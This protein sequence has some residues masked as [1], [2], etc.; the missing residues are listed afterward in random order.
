MKAMTQA[1]AVLASFVVSVLSFPMTAASQTP[2]DYLQ[3]LAGQKLI[4]R[5][6]GD[7]KEARVNKNALAKVKGTCDV[8]VQVHEAVWQRKRVR[9]QWS[10]IGSPRIAGKPGRVCRKTIV[11]SDGTVEISGFKEDETASSLAAS[12]AMVLQT[13]E[14]YLAAA[15]IQFDRAPEPDSETAVPRPE[16]PFT[17][18]KPLLSVDP[19]FSEEARRSKYQGALAI[20]LYV[21]TDGRIH[22]PNVT[23][24]L[25]YGLD[26]MALNVLPLWRFEPARKEDKSIAMPQSMEIGFHLY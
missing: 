11:Y 25:G 14:Q 23:R 13:P 16:Q 1:S 7:V 12:L 26:E 17:N 22:R 19:A 3:S 21:G 15:G 4:L 10:E 2:Q 20:S 24:K 8:A 5:H 6:F 18:P 9:L